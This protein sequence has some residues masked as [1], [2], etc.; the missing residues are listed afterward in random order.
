MQRRARPNAPGGY[1]GS[2]AALTRARPPTSITTTDPTTATNALVTIFEYSAALEARV[3]ELQLAAGDR[4]AAG[5]Q[6]ALTE[7][8][9]AASATSIA[10]IIELAELKALATTQQQQ[11][12]IALAHL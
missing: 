3:N 8:E 2:P 12:D 11:I 1:Y 4:L 9:V 10:P 5:D 7:P 6:S